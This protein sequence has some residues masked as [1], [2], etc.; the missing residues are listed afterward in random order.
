VLKSTHFLGNCLVEFASDTVAAVETYFIAQLE[1]TPE[2]STHRSMMA[3]SHADST[4]NS[5]VQ[6]FG[7]YV[8]RFEKRNDEWRVAQRRTV[9]DAIQSQLVD[10]ADSAINP[11]WT[12]GCRDQNDPVFTV[13]AEVGLI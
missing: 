7:R 10:P 4:C 6:V 13:R 3:A 8:D 12:L 9:F 5:R 2:P 1:F 11:A